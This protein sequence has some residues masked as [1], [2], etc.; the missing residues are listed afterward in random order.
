VLCWRRRRPWQNPTHVRI[1]DYL[2]PC[3]L[4]WRIHVSY[5]PGQIR[6]S[7]LSPDQEH[8]VRRTCRQMTKQNMYSSIYFE[9][10]TFKFIFFFWKKILTN[11]KEMSNVKI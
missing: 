11:W 7:Q 4:R 1:S 6:T 2:R 5:L 8:V 3:Q 10:K 9:C